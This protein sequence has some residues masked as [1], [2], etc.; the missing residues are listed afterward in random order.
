M[1]RDNGHTA[2]SSVPS[3]L[4]AGAGQ[5]AAAFE[6]DCHV[7]CPAERIWKPPLLSSTTLKTCSSKTFRAAPGSRPFVV[8]PVPALFTS[9]KMHS[10]ALRRKCVAVA[11]DCLWKD[12][13]RVKI[14]L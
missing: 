1:E 14:V 4:P 12:V 13:C 11:G 9:T 7:L 5:A 2:T 8:A 10:V 3:P 6:E